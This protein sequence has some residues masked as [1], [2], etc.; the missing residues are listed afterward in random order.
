MTRICSGYENVMSDNISS[1]NFLLNKMGSKEEILISLF[2]V[3]TS[4]EKYCNFEKKKEVTNSSVC[5]KNNFAIE[6]MKIN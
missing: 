6:F 2:P 3:T 1:A 4:S 5:E